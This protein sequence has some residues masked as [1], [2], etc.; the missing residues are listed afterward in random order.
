MMEKNPLSEEF[1]GVVNLGKKNTV[2][3]GVSILKIMS[4]FE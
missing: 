1:R 2:R 3:E 4:I